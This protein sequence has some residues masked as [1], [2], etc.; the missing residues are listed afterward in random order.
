MPRNAG[1][2]LL[3]MLSCCALAAQTPNLELIG[4]SGVYRVG[5]GDVIRIDVF[6]VEELSQSAV[7]APQGTISMPLIGE[8]SVDG[9]TTP[10]IEGQLK[11]LYGSEYLRDPQIAVTVEE[12]RS[13]PVSVVGA[14]QRPGVYQLQ[15]RRRL[16]EV[17]AMAGGLTESVGEKITVFRR[18]PKMLAGLVE[19]PAPIF[20]SA[21]DPTGTSVGPLLGVKEEIHIPVRNLL[22]MG[23]SEDL[24][25]FIEPHDVIRVGKAGVVYVMGAVQQ[26]GGFAIKDQETITVLRAV[27][28]AAGLKPHSSPQ[29]A[30]VI[31]HVDGVKKEMPVRI[32]D[33]LVGKSADL[34]LQAN[35]VL[36]IPESGAKKA[37]SRS[38]D[39]L[40]QVATGVVIFRR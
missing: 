27:S 33:V 35:D 31:R 38:V 11:K 22:K 10:E 36:F 29:K 18:D 13:Q 32:K 25:P 28:L 40:V 16:V 23:D 37:M 14:V 3:A 12:F 34:A 7:V 39:A 6:E 9:L 26:P 24:N 30:L 15:G 5:S 21:I 19:T 1:R 2:L 4:V 20:S 8:V 17:L